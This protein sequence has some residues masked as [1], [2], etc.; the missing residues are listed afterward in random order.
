MIASS[1]SFQL[2]EDVIAEG[3]K[4]AAI[5]RLFFVLS[6][7]LLMAHK[8]ELA[9]PRNCQSPTREDTASRQRYR[10]AHR[11]IRDC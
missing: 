10:T 9:P 6:E 5:G 8:G 1:S 2:G 7:G 3:H 4:E 11:S